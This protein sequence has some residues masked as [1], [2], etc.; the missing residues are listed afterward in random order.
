MG[1]MPSM[2]G[3][4]NIVGAFQ[5]N[6]CVGCGPKWNDCCAMGGPCCRGLDP[7]SGPEWESAKAGFM[8][9]LD[10]AYTI[11]AK[12][13]GCCPSI[14]RMKKDLDAEWTPK[15]NTYLGTYK[16]S[17]EVHAFYTYNGQSSTLA[18]RHTSCCS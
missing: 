11:C 18:P 15:A 9:M 16:L 10:D 1:N 5:L 3:G 8:P 14:E 4:D 6:V 7:P 2:R 12:H 13:N 17:V